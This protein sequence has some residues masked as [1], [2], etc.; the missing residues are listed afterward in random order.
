MDKMLNFK[1]EKI[2]IRKI[3]KKTDDQQEPDADDDSCD[4]SFLGVSN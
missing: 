2:Y 4:S 1:D 3:Q